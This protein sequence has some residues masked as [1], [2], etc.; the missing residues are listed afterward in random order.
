MVESLNYRADS[1]M[2]KR[3]II[4]GRIKPEDAQKFGRTAEHSA[5]QNALANILYGGTWGRKN[6]GNT[7][8]GDGWR[9]RGRG[10]KQ[11]TGRDN[12][13]RGSQRVYGDQRLVADPD[14]AAQP[15]A[16]ALLAAD[17]WAS[18]QLNAAADRDDIVAVTLGINGGDVGLKER[19]A[20]LARAKKALGVAS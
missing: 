15:E 16:A 13:S 5:H 11:I 4:W 9:F 8:A 7:L 19:K 10:F 20:W 17:F 6:L 12:Y 2:M 14:L 18:K 1:T 3:F